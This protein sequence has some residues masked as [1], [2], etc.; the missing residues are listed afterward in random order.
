MSY[1]VTWSRCPYCNKTLEIKFRHGTP[2]SSKLGEKELYTCKH[3]GQFI[4]NGKKEWPE[5]S[6]GEQFYEIILFILQ[7]IFA[8]M[9]F[10]GFGS[11]LLFGLLFNMFE[12]NFQA[13]VIISITIWATLSFLVGN[14]CKRQIKESIERYNIGQSKVTF[15]NNEDVVLP[16]PKYAKSND[17][18]QVIQNNMRIIEKK[19]SEII[20]KTSKLNDNNE[21][22]STEMNNNVSDIINN[23]KKVISYLY[24]IYDKYVGILIELYFSGLMYYLGKEDIKTINIKEKMNIFEKDVKDYIYQFFP[25][26][27][28]IEQIIE[29][30][31]YAGPIIKNVIIDISNVKIKMVS[32]QSKVLISNISPIDIENEYKIIINNREYNKISKYLDELNI[33]YDRLLSEYE[34][35]DER[36]YK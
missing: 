23:N 33:E 22:L 15:T 4:S 26:D 13:L 17:D 27:K 24:K 6:T 21:L 19:L 11:M 31:T 32:L 1:T 9:I 36:L 34:V 3:C 25:K 5:M 30:F 7:T 29:N 12:N 2:S 10:G 14:G 16:F 18:I 20:E 28:T 8:G 35:T